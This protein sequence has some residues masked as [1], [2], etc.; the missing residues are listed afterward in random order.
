MRKTS[1]VLFAVTIL[2]LGLLAACSRD[3]A[4]G[5]ADTAISVML[6]DGAPLLS[7]AYMM[8]DEAAGID[9]YDISY[10][11]TNDSDALVAALL[12][13]E[14][15]FAIA[16]IKVAAMMNNNGSGYRLAA[17]TI[18]GIMQIVSDQDVAA[19]ADL[20]DE[21]IVAFGRSGTPG[22][23]LRAVLEQNNIPYN[24]PETTN[25]MTNPDQ[26]S[27]V[28]LTAP[29][30]VRDALATGMEIGGKPAS[31][32]LLAE[33]VATA[34]TGFAGNA[35]RPGFAAKINLQDEWAKNNNGEFYPQAALIFHER[36]LVDNKEFVND[37]IALAEQS[38]VYANGNAVAAGDLAV[39]LGSVTIPNGTVV[40]NAYSAGRLP[41]DFTYAAAAKQ[42]VN[43]YLEVFLAENANL[44]G[45]KMPADSFYYE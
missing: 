7:M 18:W 38:S 8:S 6:V 37:F 30:D 19:L 10:T 3:A 2:A 16:P 23:T 33:P 25:F 12:N 32:G 9:G 24:E 11:M 28:Y 44:I 26:V 34:I 42:A 35:G 36:L 41:L 31:F 13:Q 15:D 1:A 20:R 21:T 5:G 14:P 39:S 17:V 22:I 45:G 27:I 4:A 40:G 43:A 29:S